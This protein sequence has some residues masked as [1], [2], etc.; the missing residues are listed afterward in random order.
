MHTYTP[1]HTAQCIYAQAGHCVLNIWMPIAGLLPIHPSFSF[2]SSSC[3]CCGKG[4]SCNPVFKI[5]EERRQKAERTKLKLLVCPL[6]P[7]LCP[8]IIHC[9]EHKSFSPDVSMEGNV[10]FQFDSIPAKAIV[11]QR[12]C[13][14]DSRN[15]TMSYIWIFLNIFGDRKVHIITSSETRDPHSM[16][17]P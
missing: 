9:C 7:K 12:P 2:Q 11:N 1:V 3:K 14:A 10:S 13:T 17:A 4:K 6:L 5:H 15:R 8:P 16:R